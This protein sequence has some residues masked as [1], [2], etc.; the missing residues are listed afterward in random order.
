MLNILNVQGRNQAAKSADCRRSRKCHLPAVLALGPQLT[1]SP[2]TLFF[3][4][5][6]YFAKKEGRGVAFLITAP[7][8]F[9]RALGMELVCCWRGALTKYLN[10]VSGERACLDDEEKLLAVMVSAC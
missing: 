5:R 10:K 8:R 6:T 2:H 7:S 4:L 1:Q 9:P 3:L